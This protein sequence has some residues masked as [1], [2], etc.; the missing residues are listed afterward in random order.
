MSTASHGTRAR[1][2]Q[3]CDCDLCKRGN[4]EYENHRS[5]QQVY[6]RPTADLV[7]AP[8]VPT[9]VRAL[10]DAGMGTRAIAAAAGLD[11][12]RVTQLLN[13]RPDRGSPPTRRMRPEHAAA[14]LAV[15]AA[16]ADHALVCAD[17]THRRIQALVERGWSVSKLAYRLGM[18]PANLF[19]VLKQSE[20]TAKFAR[21]ITA[22]YDALW[23]TPPPEDTWAD[24][25]A[26]SRARNYAAARGWVAPAGWDDDLI[27][28]PEADLE[29]EVARRVAAMTPAERRR[30]A[31]AVEVGAG[32]HSGEKIDDVG[33]KNAHGLVSFLAYFGERVSGPIF[34]AAGAAPPR[35][36]A[37][38]REPGQR[39]R[40][41]GGTQFERTKDQGMRRIDRMDLED[42]IG[43]A[44]E[45][46]VRR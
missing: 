29:K 28:L 21:K 2:A 18:G 30:C 5:R 11:R 8:P 39:R 31:D 27:D 42:E 7:D 9:H 35:L 36:D 19:A 15:A 40:D 37:P 25:V 6:G 34:S 17:G 41:L 20:V 32:F 44:I 45:R 10:Q 26:A 43:H 4:R 3:G 13:G 23:D 1:Y 33:C 46:L 14:L 22:L 12:K 24:R 38:L 16:P